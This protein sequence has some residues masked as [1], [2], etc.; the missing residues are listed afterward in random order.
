MD[1]QIEQI[2]GMLKSASEHNIHFA[3]LL[4]NESIDPSFMDAAQQLAA[5]HQEMPINFNYL[6][7]LATETDLDYLEE[8]G[9][10]CDEPN[11]ILCMAWHQEN[12]IHMTYVIPAE[13]N[14]DTLRTMLDEAARKHMKG[15][16][17]CET[18]PTSSFLV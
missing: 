12:Q 16:K 5:A 11:R 2:K 8:D 7:E 4:Y 9:V 10:N 15:V 14:Q 6:G 17:I 1:R 3:N 13:E 18:Q